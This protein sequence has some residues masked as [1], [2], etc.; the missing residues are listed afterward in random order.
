MAL[1]QALRSDEPNAVERLYP[2][3]AAV[4]RNRRHGERKLELCD[5]MIDIAAAMFNV[6][7]R[8]IRDP[9]RSSN[10]TARV[11]QIAMYV[12]HV[13]LGLTMHEVGQGFGRNRTTVSH[14]CHLIEDMREDEDFDRIVAT[15][16]RVAG[17]ALRHRS[18]I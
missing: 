6:S 16:E 11:R 15:I 18:G 10:A 1:M 13:A 17:A 8:E 5:C 14:A 2:P 12:A 3:R 9:G 4:R 7:G